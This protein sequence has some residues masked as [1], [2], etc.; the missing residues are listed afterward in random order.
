VLEVKSS[1]TRGTSLYPL[2]PRFLL[3]MYTAALQTCRQGAEGYAWS[4]VN[5]LALATVV[6]C[7][8]AI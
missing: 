6:C 2:R 3:C 5:T 1:V 7:V 4:Y 8:I